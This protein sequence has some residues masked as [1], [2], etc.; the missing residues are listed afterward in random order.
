MIFLFIQILF[1]IFRTLSTQFLE[2]K[3]TT[4]TGDDVC[5]LFVC[6]VIAAANAQLT[7]FYIRL[8]LF[9]CRS[10]ICLSISFGF[11]WPLLHEH[12]MPMLRYFI[13]THQHKDEMTRKK[14]RTWKKS[15][16]DGRE[17]KVLSLAMMLYEHNR[18]SEHLNLFSILTWWCYWCCCYCLFLYLSL[19]GFCRKCAHARY[20]RRMS[21]RCVAFFVA[22]KWRKGWRETN[23]NHKPVRFGG[24]VFVAYI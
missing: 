15:P 16:H 3:T 24:L 8:F 23:K 2:S 22:P 11:E 12:F 5:S 14:N 21:W 7:H 20:T 4:R 17:K 19:N 10:F 1:I 9:H 18:N 13:S 6:D